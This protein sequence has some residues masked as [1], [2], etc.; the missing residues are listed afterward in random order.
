MSYQVKLNPLKPFSRS[1]SIIGIGA[2]PFQLLMDNPETNGLGE[3]EL[4][5]Y[6]AIEAMKD[7]G[8]KSAK[9]VDFYIHAQAGPSWQSVAETPNMQVSNWFGMKGK[10]SVHHSE[11]CCT[12]YVALEQAVMYV[13][14]GVYDI[15]L[16]GACDT[17]YSC[18]YVDKPTF[19]RHLG[20]D[21]MFQRTLNMIYPKAYA[22]LT[23]RA[24]Q[25]IGSEGWIE[26]YVKENGI[27]DKIDD[28]MCAMSKQA[29][30][31]AALNPMSMSHDTYDEMARQFKM[32]DAD[33]FLRS[34]FN[35]HLGKYLRAS[36]FELKCDG[37]AAIV[38][39]PTEI[40][41]RYTDRPVEVLALGHSCLEGSTPV[42][43][44]LATEASYK[45][46]R[47]LTGLTGKDM[48]L[49]MVNDFVQPSQFLAAEAC[50]YIPKG[51]AWKYMLEGR[52]AFDGDRPVQ[53]N[54][55]RCAYGHAHGTSGLHDHYEAIK[56]MRGEMGPTQVK[57]PVKHAMLRGFGGGQN[58][59]CTILKNNAKEA[60]K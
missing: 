31:T 10:G 43:E 32:K 21:E 56:Q 51:Q 20:T 26:E 15:V 28:V 41:Y 52:M 3:S 58:L 54:G 39:C 30:R 44:K 19:M 17:S 45:Q 47:D 2:T 36:N 24:C 34:K 48:D 59:M 40:A 37:S 5:A 42:L 14:S 1:V 25:M 4:F 55:G 16:S 9:E 35:P 18:A 46:A 49:F 23:H 53:T 12:G 29:R 27:E 6:A 57:K 50:E 7:A 60:A 22:N 33:E 13:A 38:V 8:I 11:A